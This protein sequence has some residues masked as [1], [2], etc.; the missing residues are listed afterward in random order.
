MFGS[1]KKAA[2]NV[3]RFL[4]TTGKSALR[5]VGETASTIRKVGTAVNQATGGAAGAAWN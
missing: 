1:I 2:G 3:G 4:S 5:K